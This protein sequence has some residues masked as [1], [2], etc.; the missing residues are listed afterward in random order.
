M[1]IHPEDVGN[2]LNLFSITVV[3]W[4]YLN[5]KTLVKLERAE[6]QIFWVNNL[7]LH[8]KITLGLHIFNYMCLVKKTA[9]DS[10]RQ[11]NNK[12][13]TVG[14]SS[15]YF[16]QWK[17]APGWACNERCEICCSLNF[18][19]TSHN[20]RLSP[21]YEEMYVFVHYCTWLCTRQHINWRDFKEFIL[22]S[23]WSHELTDSTEFLILMII[24]VGIT[25]HFVKKARW[26]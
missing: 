9:R 19:H 25:T 20:L 10:E 1:R 23:N 15:C 5:F 16:T 18:L 24:K 6:S 7:P 13:N 11:R 2:E 22:Y 26:K 17:Y 3:F 8:N 12:L 14:D 21:T 4:S